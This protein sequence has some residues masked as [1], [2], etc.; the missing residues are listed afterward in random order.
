MTGNNRRQGLGVS[1][2]VTMDEVLR[3]FRN[4]CPY[5]GDRSGFPE[6][7]L[8]SW[9][10]GVQEMRGHAVSVDQGAVVG[11]IQAQ[12]QGVGPRQPL[13]SEAAE[14]WVIE[15]AAIGFRASTIDDTSDAQA[16]F[17]PGVAVAVSYIDCIGILA[18]TGD[19]AGMNL[20]LTI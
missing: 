1:A 2:R 11:N 5:F 19:A 14:Q 12:E 17:F 3:Q 13:V 10:D 16:A 8:S 6:I 20:Q 9:A 7:S 18:V 15:L 4:L